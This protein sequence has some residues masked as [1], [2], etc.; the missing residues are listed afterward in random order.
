MDRKLISDFDELL[1]YERDTRDLFCKR[2]RHEYTDCDHACMFYQVL[3]ASC[4][5]R[6]VIRRT[7]IEKYAVKYYKESGDV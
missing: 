5:L 2:C 3:M 1:Q 7:I 4:Y 6:F